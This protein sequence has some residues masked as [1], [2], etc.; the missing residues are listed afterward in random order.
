[1][2]AL[3]MDRL[4]RGSSRLYST[5]SSISASNV[6][7]KGV[8]DIAIV[9]SG[10]VGSALACAIGS[11]SLAKDL[12][13]AVLEA[14]P[15]GPSMEKIGDKFSN[16]VSSITP[17]NKSFLRDIGAWD[18]IENF[19]C[20]KYSNMQI[21][22]SCGNGSI[23]FS[24]D[25]VGKEA[26][27]Y[28]V[29]NVVMQAA[30][31][32]VINEKEVCTMMYNSQIEKISISAAQQ[33]GQVPPVEILLKDGTEIKTRLLVGSDGANSF[34]RKSVGIQSTQWPY[35]QSGVVATLKVDADFE[36]QTAWQR[37]LPTGPIALLPLSDEYSSLVWSTH[38]E[39]A[40]ELV[41]MDEV[42]FVDALNR[43]FTDPLDKYADLVNCFNVDNFEKINLSA[44][45]RSVLNAMQTSSFKS[46]VP[47]V[48]SVDSKSR[49]A[50]PLGLTHAL[51]YIAPRIALVGDAAHRIHPLA[52]QGVNLGLGD[53][54]VLAENI[55]RG[56]RL[57]QDPGSISILQDY[58][59][60]RKKA[61]IPV[62][63]SCDLLKRL[64]SNTIGPLAFARNF[65]LQ[66]TNAL[67]PLKKQIIALAS[68]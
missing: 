51:D 53:A 49:G 29:E 58:E 43:A 35:G 42:E 60:A 20:H 55:L 39:L 7:P 17:G 5:A 16:R 64:F 10:M 34:V 4:I 45:D 59:S 27:A 52:G 19:R 56:I 22:D 50:F 48:V 21:W 8:L 32:K 25:D 26:I 30:L 63:A 67:G 23:S 40:K 44:L 36:N 46:N 33:A 15:N 65:G 11:S 2:N 37:F 18:H 38:P 12:K 47:V 24:A 57:G 54:R 14:A 6:P 9:G 1:M 41:K 66:A 13:I 28:M 31:L 62:M 61:V 68:A 3:S